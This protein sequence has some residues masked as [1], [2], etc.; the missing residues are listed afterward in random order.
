M[1][2]HI[3]ASNTSTGKLKGT[4]G[5]GFQGVTDK[6]PAGYTETDWPPKGGCHE[7]AGGVHNWK[8]VPPTK[9]GPII[10]PGDSYCKVCGFYGKKPQPPKKLSNDGCPGPYDKPAPQKHKWEI[11]P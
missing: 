10:T 5:C 4:G 8:Q 6:I 11:Y 7:G 9:R 2:T 1:P 3:C